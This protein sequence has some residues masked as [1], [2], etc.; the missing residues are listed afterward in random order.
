LRI[1]DAHLGPGLVAVHAEAAAVAFGRVQL[2]DS[3][4]LGIASEDGLL[5]R[6]PGVDS[7]DGRKVFGAEAFADWQAVL[8]HWRSSIQEIA[9]EVKFGAAAV[10]VADEA[11]LRY[12]DVLPILRLAERRAQWEVEK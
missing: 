10:T 2:E 9:L 8:A 3:S 4:F 1:G 12:C 7:R 5:P 11:D 6:V